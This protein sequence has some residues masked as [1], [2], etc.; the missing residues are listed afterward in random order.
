MIAFF[1]I[2]FDEEFEI[3]FYMTYHLLSRGAG[4]VHNSS[5]NMFII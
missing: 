2:N 5:V 4:Y 1:V 3:F